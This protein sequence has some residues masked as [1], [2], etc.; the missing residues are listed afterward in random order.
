MKELFYDILSTKDV[1]GVMLLSVEGDLI[2]KELLFPP[3]TELENRDWWHLFFYSLKEAKEVD[4]VFENCRLYVRK[5]ELG[6]L[7]VHM[8]LFA[9]HAMIRLHTD[10]LLP[11]LKEIK[12]GKG[13][14]RLFKRKG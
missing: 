6:Y 3:F 5:T 9:P 4:L 1:K 8:G 13:L 12:A 10:L 7:L 11:S 14:R 2:F